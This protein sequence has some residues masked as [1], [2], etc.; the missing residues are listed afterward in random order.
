MQR[1]RL[2]N[3]MVFEQDDALSH[4]SNEVRTWLNEKL[5]GRW[6]SRGG[7]ISWGSHSPALMSL[8]FFLWEYMKRKL[9]KT[10]VNDILDSKERIEQEMKAKKRRDIEKCF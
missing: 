4:S 7:S 9:Y 3:K 6:N 2:N 5:N 8:D 10:K 1:K